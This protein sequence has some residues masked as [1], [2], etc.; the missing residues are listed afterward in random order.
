MFSFSRIVILAAAVFSVAA[1]VRLTA[2]DLCGCTVPAAELRVSGPTRFYLGL[3]E[4]F[5]SYGTLQEDGRRIDDPA[6]Q[7]LRSSVT[8]IYAG[9]QVTDRF[10]VQLNVPVIHRSFR[11]AEGD[12]IQR[13]SVSGLGDL[14]L[15]AHWTALRENARPQP[16]GKGIVAVAQERPSFTL[17]LFAGVKL[18]TGSTSRLREETAEEEPQPGATPSGVHGH[19]LTLGTGSVDVFFGLNAGLRY[20]RFF[21]TLELQYAVRTRGD[22]GYRFANDFSFAGGPGYDLYRSDQ[23]RVG[24]QF[25]VSGEHKPRDYFRGGRAEDTGV[26][27]VYVGPRLNARLGQRWDAQLG[28]ALPIVRENTAI[29]TVP[30]YRIQAA[31]NFRF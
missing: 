24:L 7:F 6:H 26:T 20:D 17:D 8:Q 9:W 4:Q 28:F 21:A 13:G 19:D 27:T 16:T 1:P 31:V 12:E 22:F 11:R 15:V 5:T 18:P 14:S 25:V 2:C 30:D 10:G 23:A 29:Q 3:S